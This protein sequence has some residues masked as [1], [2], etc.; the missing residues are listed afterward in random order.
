MPDLTEV[1]AES[2]ALVDQGAI[3]EADFKAWVFENPYRL[4]TESNA[5]FFKGT[6][7]ESKLKNLANV[8]V[9]AE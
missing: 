9:A 6:A 7:V 5:A 2:H 3:T 1:L 8:H 4:Y